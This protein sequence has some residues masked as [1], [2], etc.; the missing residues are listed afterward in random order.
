[1]AETKTR[2]QVVETIRLEI[3]KLEIRS[4]ELLVVRL[5][6]GLGAAT[7]TLLKRS[8]DRLQKEMGIRAFVI[9]H[10]FELSRVRRVRL[11]AAALLRRLI[12]WRKD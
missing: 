5:P 3:T 4:D 11:G 9:P 12:F 6:A 7:V 1:M 2:K 10:E 8:M